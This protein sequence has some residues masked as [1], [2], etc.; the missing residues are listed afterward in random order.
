MEP[1]SQDPQTAAALARIEAQYEALNKGQ[2]QI[3]KD[4]EQIRRD[5]EKLT[6]GSHQTSR[7]L[8]ELRTE[9]HTGNDNNRRWIQWLLA[10]IAIAVVVATLHAVLG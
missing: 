5:L 7:E 4:Q 2:E 1:Q 6:E 8:G 9:F 3:R 10:P